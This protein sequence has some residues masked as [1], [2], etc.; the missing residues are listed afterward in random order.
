MRKK[1]DLYR[2]IACID[3]N[4]LSLRRVKKLSGKF[5]VD[6]GFYEDFTKV[7]FMK[8]GEEIPEGLV[9]PSLI[10]QTYQFRH[11]KG[12]ENV[13]F[14]TNISGNGWVSL[15]KYYFPVGLAKITLA[16]QGAYPQQCI[17]ADAVKWVKR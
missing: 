5:S 10:T 14:E 12:K 7:S 17:Y 9:V 13:T 15:G 8:E 2:F 16:D 4:S 1:L 3:K 11:K 6:N